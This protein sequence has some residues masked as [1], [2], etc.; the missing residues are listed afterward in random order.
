[1]FIRVKH[2][3]PIT[4]LQPGNKAMCPRHHRLPGT[5]CRLSVALA[6]AL[7]SVL[8]GAEV[9]EA[10]SAFIP[11]HHEMF[12]IASRLLSNP[13]DESAV[14]WEEIIDFGELSFPWSQ[15]IFSAVELPK[16]SVI[17]IT[18]LLDGKSQTL[19]A[20]QLRERD[21]RSAFFN[22]SSLS[23]Q[24]I[25]GPHTTGNFVQIK[26]IFVGDVL[27]SQPRG[28]EICGDT[29]DR[30]TLR[31]DDQKGTGRLL[32]KFEDTDGLC[33]CTGFIINRP[34]TGHDKCHL[35]AGHCFLENCVGGSNTLEYAY[36]QFNVPLSDD[37]CSANHPASKDQ[38]WVSKGTI[39]ANAGG[40]G[41]DW[42]VFRCSPTLGKTTF[43]SQGCAFELAESVPS[44]DYVNIVGYGSD[45]SDQYGAGGGNNNCTCDPD[46]ST[47][48]W[49]YVQ[50]I[51]AGDLTDNSP[52]KHK[53]DT[54]PGNSG[55]PIYLVFPPY[56]GKA[57]GI[58]THGGCVSEGVNKGTPITHQDLQNAI[59]ECCPEIPTLTQ[60][61]LIMLVV[62][63]VFSTW[64]VLRRRKAVVS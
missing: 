62:L 63:I 7:L 53:V 43:Q 38:F 59:A 29:D 27:I 8:V 24:L 47:G 36:L 51:G 48:T 64:V 50:Q 37:D 60:W 12:Q 18:S 15:V 22:G 49:N 19:D 32:L 21:Y 11:A 6:F 10:Q 2:R 16:G 34:E 17:K 14:V 31:P 42:A 3:R 46:N 52:I 40:V 54:C 61:G 9:A 45:G 56:C 20:K 13:T 41:N 30:D 35:S 44:S 57:A 28:R 4:L 23:V 25:A 39:N 55:S 5:F 58:H 26:E 1:M 33:V